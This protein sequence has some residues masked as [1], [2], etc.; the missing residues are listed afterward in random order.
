MTAIAHDESLVGEET[1]SKMMGALRRLIA[2]GLG[3]LSLACFLPKAFSL[4]SYFGTPEPAVNYEYL[5]YF[6]LS[7]AFALFCFLFRDGTGRAYE[8]LPDV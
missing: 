4:P 3:I 6:V 8:D 1:G 7:G 2:L 5:A